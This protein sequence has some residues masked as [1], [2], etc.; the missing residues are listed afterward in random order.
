MYG[1]VKSEIHTIKI[2]FQKCLEQDQIDR[3]A[4]SK[5]WQSPITIPFGDPGTGDKGSWGT[6]GFHLLF[7]KGQKTWD[8]AKV[9]H[10]VVVDLCAK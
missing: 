7:K 2:F 9:E 4:D 8:M 1:I 3:R 10:K 6:S 5:P